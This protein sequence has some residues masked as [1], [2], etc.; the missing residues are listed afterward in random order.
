MA[1][2]PFS[3]SISS[4]SASYNLP[5]THH[6]KQVSTDIY[7]NPSSKCSRTQ[8]LYTP[9][10]LC[11]CVILTV[12]PGSRWPCSGLR[13]SSCEWERLSLS[14]WYW[15]YLPQAVMSTGLL[16][17]QSPPIQW[18]ITAMF[19]WTY[20]HRKALFVVRGYQAS[21]WTK[22]GPLKNMT[23]RWKALVSSM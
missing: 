11:W 2:V 10:V 18:H 15:S 12:R 20:L 23:D 16:S 22:T 3:L 14:F 5:I 7:T 8:S 13:P 6:C 17:T 19:W 4:I 9:S 21:T 1:A